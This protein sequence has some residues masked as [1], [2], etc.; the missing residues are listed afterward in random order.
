MFGFYI[1]SLTGKTL[2]CT[3]SFSPNHCKKNDKITLK[4]LE[5][6]MVE[7][8]ILEFRLTKIDET[9]IYLSI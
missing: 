7:K 1:V 6:N 8:A 3:N 5:I 4:I 9:K 2:D